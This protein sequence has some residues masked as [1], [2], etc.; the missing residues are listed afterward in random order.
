MPQ[1]PKQ[2][3]IN[4]LSADFLDFK[5]R[6][7]AVAKEEIQS[8]DM[9]RILVTG[10]VTLIL[11]LLSYFM[12]IWQGLGEL[13]VKVATLEQAQKSLDLDKRLTKLE[14]RLAA[15]GPLSS[16]P[17]RRNSEPTQRKA[18]KSFQTH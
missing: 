10:F 16:L 8:F 5:N 14:D 2:E 15:Q 6:A 9:K 13:K 3:N 1:L 4:K 12:P 18:P 11:A 7:K 17:E